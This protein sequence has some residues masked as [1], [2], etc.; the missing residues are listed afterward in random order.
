MARNVKTGLLP[1]GTP[2]RV[3]PG[4]AEP[5]CKDVLVVDKAVR[6]TAGAHP[7]VEGERPA[8]KATLPRVSLMLLAEE[9]PPAKHPAMD[10]TLHPGAPVPRAAA[11]P[12]PRT[13]IIPPRTL[14]TVPWLLANEVMR[15][16]AA[17]P[18]TVPDPRP[19]DVKA[20]ERTAVVAP[21]F[22]MLGPRAERAD[23]GRAM[24]LA[25]P[26]TLPAFPRFATGVIIRAAI[27]ASL[28][29]PVEGVVGV[30]IV[31][32]DFIEEAHEAGTD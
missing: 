2:G 25:P 17:T 18:L 27:V 8:N 21:P 28:T 19:E 6:S 7:A 22:V 29:I 23:A 16:V 1:T 12:I 31:A 14:P 32:S 9:A 13:S 10:V 30:R 26:R 4:R 24:P 20:A 11:D 5:L 15:A 3:I